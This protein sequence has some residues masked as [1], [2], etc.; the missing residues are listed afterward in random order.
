M[1]EDRIEI[2]IVE[3]EESHS[4]LICRAF[5]PLVADFRLQRAQSLREA[6][7]YLSGSLPDVAIVD[8]SLPDGSGLE[9]LPSVRDDVLYPIVVLTAHGDDRASV[10]AIRQGAIDYVIK[11]HTAFSDL[12]HT[13][14]RA[15]RDWALMRKERTLRE[16]VHESQ[17]RM[18]AV[19]ETASDAIIVV[20][21]DGIIESFNRMAESMFGYDGPSIIG[22]HVTKLMPPEY[23]D[24]HKAAFARYV[25]AATVPSASERKEVVGLRKDGTTFPMELATSITR[26]GSHII[27]TGI[28][29]DI[30][31]R[32][33]GEV[34]I[35]ELNESLERRVRIRTAELE[36]VAAEL[37][38]FSYSVSHDL[39]Q[40]LRVINSFCS[41][42]EE[43]VGDRLDAKDRDSFSRIQATVGRMSGMIDS[44]LELSVVSR[45]E[46]KRDP[47]DLSA[48]AIE[49]AR[50][51]REATP[52]REV[53]LVI[54]PGL[55]TKGNPELLRLLL[56]NLLSNAWK[57]T[58]EREDARI[59]FGKELGPDGETDYYVRDNGVGFDMNYA[60][61]LF[62]P[63]QRLHGVDEF[64]GTG[65]GLA[66]ALRIVRLHGG[67]ISAEAAV[68]E[69]ATFS[70]TLP[71]EP[72]SDEPVC[73]THFDGTL[74]S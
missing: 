56:Q 59:E 9:L 65:I 10:E 18:A 61:K 62:A 11:S 28:G 7:S 64:E 27:V 43:D 26:L 25:G 70:F 29:S 2:L 46:L 67:T 3:D 21:G 54:Q 20:D 52:E 31:E 17:K 24:D 72:S 5:E 63:F 53:E 4:E 16:T 35:L 40:P 6:R 55:A 13:V 42:L 69:G 34:E 58:R 38:S 30:T 47:V 57:F 49:L 66:T 48:L 14:E 1:T 41:I 12:P 39:R 50:E 73:V 68:E 22:R 19:L 44:L 32:K 36:S 60:K 37:R 23:R 8:L 15:L 51:L 71:A 74:E 33:K 45:T